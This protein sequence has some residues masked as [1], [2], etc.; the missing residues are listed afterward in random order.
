MPAGETRRAGASPV[1]GSRRSLWPP[2][3]RSVDPAGL[4][5]SVPRPHA[6]SVAFPNEG[7]SARPRQALAPSDRSDASPGHTRAPTEERSALLD[8]VSRHLEETGWAAALVDSEW[9]LVWVS[10]QL[11][12]FMGGARDAE[13]GI[14][15]HFCEALQETA[16]RGS[17]TE[18][19]RRRWVGEHAPHVAHDTPGGIDRIRELVFAEDRELLEGLAPV[20]PPP[21]WGWTIDFL[22]DDLPA[23]SARCLAIRHESG[24]E[25][26]GTSLLYG[27]DLPATLLALLARGDSGMFSRMARLVEPARRSAAILFVDICSSGA[28]ARR[29][30]T[31]SYFALIQAIM[32]AVDEVLARHQGVVGKH[33]GDGATGF[34]LSDDLGSDS[35]TARAAI[36]AAGEVARVAREA[37]ADL[38]EEGV[39]VDPEEVAVRVGVHWGWS[40]FMGQVVRGG[41][42]EVSALGDEVN[43]CARIEESAP[44]GAV[45]ASKGLVERLEPGDAGAL[46]LD[47]EILRYCALGDLPG[48]T[49][50][51]RRDAGGIAVVDLSPAGARPEVASHGPRTEETPA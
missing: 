36:E 32:T 8:R 17:I 12:L 20:V 45:L 23:A 2:P 30:P 6:E 37:A 22:Q 14:G 39:P 44:D 33:V 19:T 13:L 43:E 27:A 11:R 48:A 47:R 26:V 10:D 29:L 7:G 35:A 18:E 28:L 42:L 51:A 15:R 50:K 31:A 25:L 5:A 38:A 9:T 3:L 40:L 41:R 21:L 16:W 4:L 34:F 49:D 24:G 46:R 1:T